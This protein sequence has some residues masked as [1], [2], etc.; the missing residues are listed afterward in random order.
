M[1]DMT[2]RL[3]TDGK[4]C[5]YEQ[6][7]EHIKKEIREEK[8]LA[9]ERLPSTRSLAA[10][11]QVARSTVDY[12]YGQLLSEGY[13]EARPCK[14]YFVCPVEGLLSL[15]GSGGSVW[16]PGRETEGSGGFGTGASRSGTGES[17]QS[18]ACG[19][20]GKRGLPEACAQ[21]ESAASV[22]VDFSPYDIDMSGFPFSVWKKITRNILTEANAELFA[23]GEAQGDLELRRTIC[24]YLHSSRGVNCRPEQIIVGAGNDYLL[25]LLEKILGRHVRIAMENPTYKRSYRIFQSFAYD[26]VTV[27]MDEGG[28]QAGRLGQENVTAVYCMPSHQFPTGIVMPIGRRM[29]LLKWAGGEEGRYLIEDDYDSEFRYL[30]KPIPALQ[31][32]DK[33][34]KVIYIGTFSKAIAPAIRVSFMVLPDALLEKYLRDCSFYSCTVSRIDQSILNEFIRD[35]YFERHLNKMRKIYRAKHDLLLSELQ[36]F[37]GSFDISGENAGLHLLLTSKKGVPEN[38]LLERAA[39]EGVRLYGLSESMTKNA[40]ASATV[41]LG[42]GGLA[43][44]QLLD[45]ITRL[46]RAW[47]LS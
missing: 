47:Q 10:Y 14:G 29:E 11:L 30:G 31:A 46:Q 17:G 19:E 1:Y 34:A 22:R 9:G 5:L 44:T 45:G 23:R 13:I 27:D 26:V 7:Y 43:E 2:I 12:A 16:H 40:S 24:R 4:S 32:S 20:P 8:L 6:I 35:G 3:Q 33:H 18:G 25:L 37:R 41:L 28:I 21:P 36:A 42:F 38:V 39:A 15:D